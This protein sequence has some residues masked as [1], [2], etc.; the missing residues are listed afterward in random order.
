MQP[1]DDAWL[2]SSASVEWYTPAK[3]IEAARAVLGGIDFDPASCAE[4]NAVV[5]APSYGVAGLGLGGLS[6]EWHGRV[7]LNPPYGKDIRKWIDKLISEFLAGRT[8]AAIILLN[9]VLDRGWFR[10][11]DDAAAFCFTDHR[12]KF[13]APNGSKPTSPVSG[14][15]FVYLGD[16][17]E[18]FARHFR[19]FGLVLQQ[20]G[21]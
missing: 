6:L 21:T 8:T 1:H 9:A 18:A 10:P 17:V 14:N 2:R 12:I 13:L 5:R 4:A 3:Y 7:W 19:P 15:V 20:A 11:L 16:D